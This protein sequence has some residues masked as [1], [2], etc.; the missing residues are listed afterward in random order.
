MQRTAFLIL[1]LFS[2]CSAWCEEVVPSISGAAYL[3]KGN[4]DSFI[5]RDF[6]VLICKPE[7]MQFW[8]KTIKAQADKPRLL[9]LQASVEFFKGLDQYIIKGTRTN[10]DAKYAL[11]DVPPDN[12]ILVGSLDTGT[13]V[14]FWMIPITVTKDKPIEFDFTTSSAT[15]IQ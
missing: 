12:Y 15:L 11:K 6:H 14:A 2:V 4:G 7:V 10:I 9:M 13:S 3:T 5:L 1:F 8:E